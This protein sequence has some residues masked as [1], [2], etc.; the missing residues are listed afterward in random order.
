VS[1]G[2]SVDITP[3][4]FGISVNEGTVSIATGAEI[5]G[6]LLGV[7]GGIEIDTNTGQVVGGSLGGEI[8]G[9]E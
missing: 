5:P 8:G 4:D 1:G 3:V 2:V 6:G 7:S 9:L